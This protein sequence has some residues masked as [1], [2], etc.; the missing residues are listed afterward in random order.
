LA[1]SLEK[2]L[3]AS[4]DAAIRQ[5]QYANRS[6]AS[7]DLIRESLVQKQWNDGDEVAGAITLVYD[8]HR[9]GLAGRLMHIEHDFSDV[10]VSSQHIHLA[11]PHHCLEILAVKALTRRMKNRVS[12]VR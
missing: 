11:P 10:I 3:I 2:D 8:H 9:R 5:R 6:D 4:F 7:R 12:H 1:Y